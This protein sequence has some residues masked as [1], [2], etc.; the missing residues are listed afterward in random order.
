MQ[1]FLPARTN[2]QLAE[3]SHQNTCRCQSGRG[4]LG[5]GGEGCS[6]KAAPAAVWGVLEASAGQRVPGDFGA[7]A[8]RGPSFLLWSGGCLWRARGSRPQGPPSELFF[9]RG[10]RGKRQEV[11]DEV[12]V[13]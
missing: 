11:K 8:G 6:R 1:A 12:S 2:A 5:S 13:H 4:P 7:G 3:G 10:R 9:C